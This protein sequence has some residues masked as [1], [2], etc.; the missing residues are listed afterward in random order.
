MLLPL[1]RQPPLLCRVLIRHTRSLVPRPACTRSLWIRNKRIWV[2]ARGCGG[3]VAV[4]QVDVARRRADARFVLCT[5]QA[6]VLLSAWW[7]LVWFTRL[8][9]WLVLAG[10][11]VLRRRWRLIIALRGWRRWGRRLVWRWLILWCSTSIHAWG[12]GPAIVA[13]LPLALVLAFRALW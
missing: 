5:T 1:D 13:F 11:R 8:G 4:I 6:L 12:P 3:F 2:N 10:R 9:R 7:W